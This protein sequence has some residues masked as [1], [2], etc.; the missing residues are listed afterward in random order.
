[1]A[2]NTITIPEKNKIFNLHNEAADDL[3]YGSRLYEYCIQLSNQG[4][5]ETEFANKIYILSVDWPI[6]LSI[7]PIVEGDYP[8]DDD[9]DEEDN[10][11]DFF[12]I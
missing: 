9:D 8:D 12:A 10:N 7:E 6:D 1:M 3:I 5:V 4:K 2:Q 11:G